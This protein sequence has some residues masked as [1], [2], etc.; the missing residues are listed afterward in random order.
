[1]PATRRVRRKT[2]P[3]DARARRAQ[4]SGVSGGGRLWIFAAI[5]IILLLS[6]LRALHLGFPLERDE[7]EFGYIAQEM[8]RGVPMYESAYTQK[9]P[10]TYLIYALFL[11]VFG[12]STMG[13]H[14]GLLLANA[15]IMWFVFLTL[16]KTHDGLAGC[17]GALVFGVMALS[18]AI[19]GFAGHATTFVGLFAVAGLYALLRARERDDTLLYVLSGTCFGLAFLMKQSGIF[20]APLAL[21]L[22]AIDAFSLQPRQPARLVRRALA[23]GVGALAPMLLTAA[24][25]VAIGKFPLFWFWTFTLAGDFAGQ[26]GP[27][28]AVRNL[29]DNTRVVTA[30]FEILWALAAVGVVATLRDAA[31]GWKRYL[32]ATFAAAG[33]LSVLPG[34][35]FTFHYYISVLPAVALLVGAL[36]GGLA[37]RGRPGHRLAV[38]VSVWALI[39]V[40]LTIGVGR[41]QLY[42]FGLISDFAAS[43]QVYR[44]NP[45]AESVEIGE[46]LKRHTTPEDRIAILGS[47]TQVLFYAQRRSA[48]RFVNTYFLTADHPRNLEMQQELIRDIE[49]A[50]PKYVVFVKLPTSWSFSPNSPRHIVDWAEKY[51]SE[52]YELEGIVEMDEGGS[53]FRW[54][55]EAH[56]RPA[57]SGRFIQ[58]LRRLDSGGA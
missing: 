7:G 35:Y 37:R 41:Y 44:G 4:G 9:L 46:Y 38:A 21:V 16:R 34:F 51:C 28:D 33:V 18:P 27:A 2:S 8:L 15:A 56:S 3:P 39:A 13:I 12:Q 58:I 36:A 45:F 30:G 47:E 29:R 40:G 26:V 10:G 55:P 5:G 49:R 11:S 6:S 1:M 57:T 43:R 32:Y 53:A 19:L 24:Y 42:Y 50:R 48:S 20:F 52:K 17:V 22:M 54:G 14:T 23:L 25:Y 31:L